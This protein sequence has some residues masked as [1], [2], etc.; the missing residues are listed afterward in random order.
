MVA[1]SYPIRSKYGN[2]KVVIDNITFD[3]IKEGKRY[4]ELKLLLQVKQIKDLQ[5]HPSFLLQD[6]F[7]DSAGEKHRSITYEGDFSYRAI[8]F[9]RTNE[10][11]IVED[12]KPSLTFQTQVYKIKK[13]MFLY[14]YKDVVFREI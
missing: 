11:L 14:K 1:F 2:K 4:K 10:Q 13:K 6:K 12:V 3:S 8:Q 5:I 9:R 7:T